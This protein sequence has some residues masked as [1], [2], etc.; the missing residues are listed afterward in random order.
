VGDATLDDDQGLKKERYARGGIPIYWTVNLRDGRVEVYSDPDQ[1]TG[2]YRNRMVFGPGEQ[3]PVVI[4][5]QEVCQV[6]VA[7]LLPGRP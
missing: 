4:D 2:Q 5:G 3:A 7:D 6:A 1:T